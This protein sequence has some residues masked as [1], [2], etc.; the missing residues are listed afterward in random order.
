MLSAEQLNAFARYVHKTEKTTLEK[1]FNAGPTDWAERKHPS[2]LSA[3]SLTLIGQMPLIGVMLYIFFREGC[4]IDPQRAVDPSLLLLVGFA[5]EWFSQYD[6]MDGQRARRLKCGS[7]LGRIVDEA[8][9]TVAMTCYS[10]YVAYM[11]NFDS[12]ILE[13][14]FLML[15]LGAYGMEIRFK[16]CGTL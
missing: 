15:N 4:H 7:P 1:W 3:N 2:F 5:I 12:R 13:T 8:G 14:V 11:F 10:I 9:D 6:M 16:V